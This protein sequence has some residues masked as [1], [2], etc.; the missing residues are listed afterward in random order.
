MD[1]YVAKTKNMEIARNFCEQKL[2]KGV[3]MVG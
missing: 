3:G 2:G 1:T